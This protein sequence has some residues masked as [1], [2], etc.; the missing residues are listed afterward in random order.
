MASNRRR[1]DVVVKFIIR[2]KKNTC[3]IKYIIP[4]KNVVITIVRDLFILILSPNTP[5]AKIRHKIL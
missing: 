5:Y 1:K 2:G 3:P 4:E